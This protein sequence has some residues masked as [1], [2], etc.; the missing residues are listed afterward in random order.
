MDSWDG[1]P[2]SLISFSTFTNRSG[3]H[4]PGRHPCAGMKIAKLEIK[5]VLAMALLGYQYDVVD[6]NGVKTDYL[7]KPDRND[8]KVSNICTRLFTLIYANS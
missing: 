5:I 3:L 2:V 6:E 1:V 4:P 8:I 7:P